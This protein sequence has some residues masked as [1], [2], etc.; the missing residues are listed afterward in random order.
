ML[1]I[2]PALQK[3][4]TGEAK[5]AVALAGGG[6]LGAF[7]ELGV[8]HALSEAVEGL[9]LT[10]LDVYVGVSSGSMIA[11]GLANGFDTTSMGEIFIHDESTLFP[12]SPAVLLRPAVGEYLRRV[13]E[14]PK[15]LST[16]LLPIRSRPAAQRMARG[17]GSARLA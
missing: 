12:F 4:G 5:T 7:Y 9:Q 8:L 17:R 16:W 1:T 10:E 13:S 14:L 3:R 11:A 15:A 6:P 2:E